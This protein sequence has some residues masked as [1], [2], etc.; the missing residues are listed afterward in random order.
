MFNILENLHFYLLRTLNCINNHKRGENYGV[1]SNRSKSSITFFNT[2]STF[3]CRSILA[4]SPPS[5]FTSLLLYIPL[6]LPPSYFTSLLLYI[7]LTLPP[8]FFLYLPL[9][10]P[11]SYFTSLLLYLPLTLPPSS[12]RKCTIHTF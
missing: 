2:V 12:F 1:I 9:T 5:Y 4:F 6:T 8:S 11:P 10:L 3:K 7:P